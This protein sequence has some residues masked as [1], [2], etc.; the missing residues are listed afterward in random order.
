MRIR[1]D[2]KLQP[3][4]MARRG[5][6]DR[7]FTVA[8]YGVR[9]HDTALGDATCRVGEKLRQVAAVQIMAASILNP[10]SL[11]PRHFVLAISAYGIAVVAARVFR[12]QPE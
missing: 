8:V 10:H 6:G 2:Q 3:G 9:W 12:G 1:A 11:H 7:I 4:R 5:G